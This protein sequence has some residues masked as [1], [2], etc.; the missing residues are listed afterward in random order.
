MYLL[1]LPAWFAALLIFRRSFSDWR[2][3]ALAASVVWGVV[4][5][6]MTEG[7]S[8]FHALAFVPL[9]VSWVLAS[10]ASLAIFILLWPQMEFSRGT[11]AKLFGQ[12]AS[13]SGL[14]V[15][16]MC[17]IFLATLVVALAA[18]PNTWDSMTYHMA[19]VAN[20]VDHRSV[21]DYPT[22]IIRQLYLGPWA[23]FAITHLQIL[24]GGDRLANCVQYLA[25]LGSVL[26]V[27]L[28]AKKLGAA[29]SAQLFASVFCATIPMGIL[30]AS[31]TQTDYVTAFW[32]V[33]FLNF[34]ISLFDSHSPCTRS[35]AVLAGASL[36]LASL[37]KMTAVLIAAPF[38][39]WLGFV[40]IRRRQVRAATLLLGILAAAAL[41]INAG[42]ILRNERAFGWALGPR[43]ET[44]IYANE[45]HTP[46]ALASN[47]I[48]NLA[49]HLG[50]PL[51]TEGILGEGILATVM[52]MQDWT[53]L[54]VNDRRTTFLDT[55]FGYSLSLN[56]DYAGNPLHLIFA[57]FAVVA[58]LLGFR[59]NRR[60]GI[61]SVCLLVAFLL[62]C[63]YLKWQ[64]WISRLQ[65]PMFVAAAPLFGLF[66]SRDALRRVAPLLAGLLLFVGLVYATRGEVRPLVGT[67]TVLVRPRTDLYFATRNALRDP[68]IAAATVLARGG[69]STVG[70]IS[71]LDDWEYPLRLLVRMRG[72]SNV[73][74]EHISVQNPSRDCPPDIPTNSGLPEKI[75]VIGAFDP[76]DIPAGYRSAFAS[77][78]IRVFER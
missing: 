57:G 44:A 26:G 3:A 17:L 56:E 66:L 67:G 43:A 49:V 62:F 55:R 27:S 77:D 63:G 32:F 76:K 35:Q 20:W 58:A 64:P 29:S 6:V 54:D 39:L 21:R 41:A 50:T 7:L 19:R 2:E 68:F 47:V 74:F 69:P 25:M 36:G 37:T 78:A 8:L 70:I 61:Y 72:G 18:P 14:L 34:V 59:Q 1:I 65:L 52:R 51:G 45:I 33:V 4:V 38:I 11:L 60:A 31:S 40:L 5:V 53:G 15:F 23:E 75:V 30:Q 16:G 10:C 73:Q 28:V 42:H 24:S 46:R 48:R 13:P 71:G 12:A 9:L 22:H